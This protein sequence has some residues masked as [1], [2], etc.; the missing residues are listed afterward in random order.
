M[1]LEEIDRQEIAQRLDEAEFRL[2]NL[3]QAVERYWWHEPWAVER[4]IELRAQL[5]DLMKARERLADGR[6]GVCD[7]CGRPISH[8]RLNNCVHVSNCLAC[9]RLK[10]TKNIQRL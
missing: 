4:H 7:G 2:K 10:Q 3:I 1:G 6:F 5:Y 8:K 9:N